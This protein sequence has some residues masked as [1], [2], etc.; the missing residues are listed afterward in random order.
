MPLYIAH[1]Y[2]VYFCSSDSDS[3]LLLHAS[4]TPLPVV[5]AVYSS[6][7]W[8][9]FCLACES[10]WLVVH[11][12]LPD[13][14]FG[15]EKSLQHGCIANLYDCTSQVCCHLHSWE[16][17]KKFQPFSHFCFNCWL[18][19][20]LRAGLFTAQ[21]IFYVVWWASAFRLRPVCEVYITKHFCSEL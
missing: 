1:D 3:L 13:P 2:N 7:Y 8:V 15:C 21:L 12:Y 17:K 14:V 20:Y 4:S 16:L 19:M 5:P 11:S 18:G 10:D 9:Q 6:K